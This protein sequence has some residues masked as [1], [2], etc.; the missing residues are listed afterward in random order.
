MRSLL[1]LPL[2]LAAC[3]TDG[4]YDELA[5]ESDD[6]STDGKA[7]ATP[8]GVYTYFA[9]ELD[10]RKCAAPACGGFFLERINRTTTVCHDGSVAE[11]CYTPELDWA[12]AGL[13]EATRAQL[14]DAAALGAG[15]ALVRG[16]F[17]PVGTGKVGAELGRFVITEAWVNPTGA[18]PS[19]VFA[20]IATTPVVCITSPC[21]NL[22]ER[23]LNSSNHA[24]IADVE[25]T[26]AQLAPEQLD[27]CRA[28]M[29]QPSGLI[30]A[31]DRYQVV[32]H[33]R[34]ARGR[35]ASAVFLRLADAAAN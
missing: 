8:G 5:G 22:I 20:K 1:A 25:W 21:E 10:T 24:M 9:I 7:D 14:A 26:G 3:A 31:G 2:V 4:L 23:G 11:R 27:R 18:A 33:G 6:A 19:G 13:A 17:A 32:D 15:A 29:E 35:T 16:R 34:T 30:V 28:G 12:E